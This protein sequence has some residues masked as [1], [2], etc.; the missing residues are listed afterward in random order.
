MS[1]VITFDDN[2]VERQRIVRSVAHQIDTAPAKADP[3]AL[4][5]MLGEKPRFDGVDIDAVHRNYRREVSA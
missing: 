4:L 5:R 3:F 1:T 2:P